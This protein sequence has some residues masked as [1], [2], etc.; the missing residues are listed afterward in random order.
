MSD[1]V[2][3]PKAKSKPV[4]M[5]EIKT[6][7]MS[8]GVALARMSASAGAKVASHAMGG[9][10]TGAEARADRF[11]EFLKSQANLLTKELGRLKGSAMKVGQM[12]SV[13][14]EHFFPPEVNQILK[15]LQSD[16]P[17]LEW[18]AIEKQLRR[19]LGPEKLELLEIEHEPA[20]SASLGQ[21]H[22]A[23]VLPSGGAAAG[24]LLALKI[25]YPGVDAAIDSDIRTLKSIFTMTR[26]IPKGPRLDEIFAEVREMLRREVDYERELEETLEAR[27]LLVD[28]PRFVVPEVFPEFSSKRVL[29]TS[30]EEGVPVDSPEVAALPQETRDAIASAAL[31]LYFRELFEW[32]AVQTDPHFGNYRVR[33]MPDGSARL[34]LFDFGAVRRVPKR[35]LDPYKEFISAALRKDWDAFDRTACKM[36][37]MGEDDPEE[38]RIVFRE[39]CSLIIE[40]FD[41]GKYDW[42]TSD[43]PRRVAMK[44]LELKDV[45]MKTKVGLRAPPREVV[46]LDRK[47]GGIFIFLHVLKAQINAREHLEKYV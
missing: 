22:R 43:L 17:P 21:V 34:V 1:E 16:S 15:S 6:G 23:R 24:C 29:A 37:F 20:A 42:G 36:G 47:M 33:L 38:L 14:G 40:P 45:S 31:D 32:A 12:L 25:Q 27:R 4:A 41:G 10:F 19:Q 44:A 8:R 28:D 9:L 35:F 46:F 39:F 2:K 3:I 30:F 11:N 5:K 26:L 18:P 13:Y 7:W